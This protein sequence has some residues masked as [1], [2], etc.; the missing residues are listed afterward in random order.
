[1]IRDSFWNRKSSLIFV[2]F[3][4]FVKNNIRINTS[5][6]QMSTLSLADGIHMLKLCAYFRLCRIIAVLW[7]LTHIISNKISDNEEKSSKMRS[8]NR[9]YY[10]NHQLYEIGDHITIYIRRSRD[11]FKS[12]LLNY[13]FR[14]WSFCKFFKNP[15]TLN[16]FLIFLFFNSGLL[17]HKDKKCLSLSLHCFLLG[18]YTCWWWSWVPGCFQLTFWSLEFFCV[19]EVADRWPLVIPA[20]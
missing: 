2:E 11:L 6:S 14:S 10:K 18:C 15:N 20:L 3:Y 13:L 5:L 8:L 4:F 16:R 1:M 19:A 9:I 7:Y 12:H 17:I